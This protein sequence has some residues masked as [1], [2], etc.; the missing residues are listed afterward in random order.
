MSGSCA[1]GGPSRGCPIIFVINQQA[2]PSSGANVKIWNF[3]FDGTVSGK[4]LAAAAIA[5]SNTNKVL[6]TNSSVRGDRKLGIQIA[7][8]TATTV[9]YVTMEMVR[10][11]GAEDDGGAGIWVTLS[12]NTIIQYNSISSPTYYAAG[13]PNDDYRVPS[14]SPHTMDLVSV[15]GSS[16]TRV[17][18]NTITYGNTAGIYLTDCNPSNGCTS[19]TTL[20]RDS[21]SLVWDND[22]S[23]FRQHALD[24]A[25]CDS[26]VVQNN[27]VS[28]A[29][30]AGLQ[31]GDCTNATVNNNTISSVAQNPVYYTPRGAL[32]FLW[33]TSN[34]IVM[35][36]YFHGGAAKY[37]VS[38]K[39]G[40]EGYGNPSNNSVTGNNLW[41]GTSGYIGGATSGNSISPNTLN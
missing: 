33:G 14:T 4:P 1:P 30:D 23:Y 20:V 21:N 39:A 31:M 29:G 6:I 15:I 24:F 19:S 5:L 10:S 25:H 41:T 35:N 40:S 28:Y 32:Y 13:L 26:T 18:H 8:S 37:A 3:D 34:S 12:Q 22:I 38:F 7:N 36:N 2:N 9:Q 11:T 17:Q 27:R 16:G